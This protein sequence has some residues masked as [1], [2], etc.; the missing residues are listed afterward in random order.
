MLLSVPHPSG[1]QLLFSSPV[2]TRH[3]LE[4]NPLKS[5]ASRPIVAE[6]VPP[7]PS[8]L[9]HPLIADS[10][11]STA[12]F[13]PCSPAPASLSTEPL[14]L[15]LPKLCTLSPAPATPSPQSSDAPALRP[16]RDQCSPLFE[17]AQ[18]ARWKSTGVELF[19][20]SFYTVTSCVSYPAHVHYGSL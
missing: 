11:S 13:S 2:A 4:V 1:A 6:V 8:Q 14:L 7:L 3:H 16:P 5:S 19:I 15:F 20:T 10:S 17:A 12:S 9:A 18:S